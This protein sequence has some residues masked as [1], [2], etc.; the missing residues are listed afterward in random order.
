MTSVANAP[1]PDSEPTR[2]FSLS[3]ARLMVNSSKCSAKVSRCRTG[4]WCQ[5]RSGT[6][7]CGYR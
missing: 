6:R 5:A 7:C 2:Y 3:G 4:A 1:M